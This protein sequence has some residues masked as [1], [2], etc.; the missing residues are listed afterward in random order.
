MATS[1]FWKNCINQF[2]KHKS[3]SFNIYSIIEYHFETILWQ[4]LLLPNCN[5]LK[6][7]KTLGNHH[8]SEFPSSLFL[9]NPSLT[10]VLFRFPIQVSL[11]L[12]RRWK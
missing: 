1:N 12:G 3:A 2:S 6:G 11:L 9:P 4:K 8:S 7:P 10:L 5:Y